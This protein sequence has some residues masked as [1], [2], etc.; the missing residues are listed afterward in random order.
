M[1]ARQTGNNGETSRHA[2][3]MQHHSGAILCLEAALGRPAVALVTRGRGEAAP[4]LEL[5][6]RQGRRGDLFRGVRSLLEEAGVEA[7]R[8]GRI[9][10]GLGP[11][12]FTGV[13]V[14]LAL[15]SGW[16]LASSSEVSLAGVDAPSLL[17]AAAGVQL[18]HAVAIPIGRLRV[19][20]VVAEPGGV[21][22]R[23]ARLIPVDRLADDSELVSEP[24]VVEPS[25]AE[26]IPWPPG[27]R[28]VETSERPVAALARLA[29]RGALAWTSRPLTPAYLLPPDAVLPAAPGA[30]R[31]VQLLREEGPDE[32]IRLAM[33]QGP[34]EAEAELRLSPPRQ[35]GTA[36]VTGVSIRAGAPAGTE[37]SLVGAALEQARAAGWY[38]VELRVSAEQTDRIARLARLGFVPVAT[39]SDVGDEAGP[40]VVLAVVLRRA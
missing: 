4:I 12:S 38:R 10:V 34:E 23:T 25:A 6:T 15:A 22:A 35:D 24:L 16:R 1:Q 37:D 7:S 28:L 40:T 18:P 3:D 21:R 29:G 20:R 8:V 14:A 19:L 27:M 31:E 11:G 17:T 2:E 36:R 30:G 32:S 33:L 26:G 5:P 39:E 13:R 9:A